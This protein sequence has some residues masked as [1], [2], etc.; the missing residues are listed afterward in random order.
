MTDFYTLRPGLLVSMQTSIKGNVH[1][2]Q[3]EIESTHITSDG[4]ERA[5]WETTRIVSDPAEHDRAIKVRTKI[6]GLILSVCSTSAFG[7]LCPNEKETLLREAILEARSLTDDFNQT[8]K[9]TRMQVNVIYGRIAQDDVDAVR[10]ITGEIRTLMED[11]QQGLKTLDVKAIRDAAN[12]AKQ[13]GEMLSPDAKQRLDV[14]IQAARTSARKIVKA[15]EAAAVEIDKDAIRKI[16]MQ[17]TSFL[18]MDFEAE[19][20][21]VMSPKMDA[22]N[23][24]FAEV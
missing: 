10:A 17:R 19:A 4:E 13:V 2:G 22:R 23:L 18:D 20:A 12:K 16:D 8:A 3:Q 5:R 15:G 21:Q 9:L 11:M 1:Y 7:L 6:R 14:A 24:D